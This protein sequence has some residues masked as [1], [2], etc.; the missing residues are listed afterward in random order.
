MLM[1]L[2]GKK[3]YKSGVLKCIALCVAILELAAL[4]GCSWRL[5]GRGERIESIAIVPFDNFGPNPAIQGLVTAE[6]MRKMSK[7]K[8][9]IADEKELMQF[10]LKNRVRSFASLTGSLAA[11]IGKELQVQAVLI[12]NVVYF[13]DADGRLQLGI[14]ARLI[15]TETGRLLWADYSSVS[16]KEFTTI[17]GFGEVRD[18]NK[19]VRIAVKRLFSSFEPSYTQMEAK[20]RV[21]VLPFR[22][23][24]QNKAA[25]PMITEMF[26]VELFKRGKFEIIELGDVNQVMLENMIRRQGELDYKKIEKFSNALDPDGILIGSVEKFSATPGTVP[27]LEL[28]IR[29]INVRDKKIIWLDNLEYSGEKTFVALTW[30]ELKTADKTA[31]QAVSKLGKRL[32]NAKWN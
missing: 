10:L 5:F 12:G 19:L 1:V 18:I 23:R 26:I 8:V 27:K 32:E 2:S 22:N 9:R 21:A 13:S 15:D 20:Y 11:Q 16:G 30:D 24:S 3:L 28:S 29:L 25:G 7:E 14:T 4:P 6:V 31:Y 17:M